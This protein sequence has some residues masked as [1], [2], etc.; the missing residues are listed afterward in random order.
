M[1]TSYILE[2]QNSLK[3]YIFTFRNGREY[4]FFVAIMFNHLEQNLNSD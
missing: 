4:F 1:K 3:H 2:H